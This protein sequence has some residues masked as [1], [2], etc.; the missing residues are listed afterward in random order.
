MMKKK[1]F[2]LLLTGIMLL[3]MTACSMTEDVN[4]GVNTPTPT[5]ETVPTTEPTVAPTEALKPTAPPTEVPAPAAKTVS[6]LPV[7]IDMNNLTD[8][9]VAVSFEKGDAY[10][11]DNGVMQLKV[12]VYT[13]DLYDMVD[14]AM[15]T[16]GDT[17]ILRG[18]EVLITDLVRTEYGS[19]QING[20]LD[21]GGYELITNESTVYFETGYSDVKTYFELG[22]TTIKVSEDFI[23]T[24]KMDLDKGET[25]YYPGDFL[26]DEAGIFYHFVPNNTTIV[27]QNGQVIAMER[28]YTP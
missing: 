23:F 6:P 26:T 5:N 2:A 13:Y 3:S 27:I 4:A 1:L 14:I 9:T 20:G 25:T 28:I 16:P 24:D 7:T 8:C 15:L 21:M 18:D 17:I 10:V 19:V 12:K 22:E 11:D